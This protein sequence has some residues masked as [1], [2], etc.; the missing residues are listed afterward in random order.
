MNMRAQDMLIIVERKSNLLLY[1]EIISPLSSWCFLSIHHNRS[2]CLSNPV[3]M[4]H[5]GIFVLICFE[6]DH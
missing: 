4:M 6:Y 1:T 2:R 3:E 5:Y